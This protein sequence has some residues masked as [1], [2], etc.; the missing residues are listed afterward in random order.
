[1][2]LACISTLTTRTG[3][4]IRVGRKKEHTHPKLIAIQRVKPGPSPRPP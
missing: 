2:N 1:M 4:Y 3:A